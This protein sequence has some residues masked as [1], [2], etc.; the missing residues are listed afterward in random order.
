[1]AARRLEPFKLHNP[2]VKIGWLSAAGLLAVGILLGFVVLGREQQN[3]P[4]LGPWS[5]FCSA[6]GL[7]PD[8]RPANEPQPPLRT[9]TR[10]A[11]TR[12]TLRQIADGNAKKVRLSP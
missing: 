3:G 4:A 1:M 9:P 2:W 10:V 6:L 5:A 8:V 12:A 11:W 7:S